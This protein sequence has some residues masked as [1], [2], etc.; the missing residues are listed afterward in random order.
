MKG[1]QHRGGKAR[2]R[3]GLETGWASKPEEQPGGSPW[4]QGGC[5]SPRGPS[6][7]EGRVSGKARKEVSLL[8]SKMV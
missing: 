3:N 8:P 1:P 2:G 6:S 5:G 4:E 7:S